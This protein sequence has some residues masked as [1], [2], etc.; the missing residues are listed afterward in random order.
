LVHESKKFV[1][2]LY[3]EGKDKVSAAQKTAKEYTDDMMVQVKK[4]PLASVM[5]AAG[6]GFIISS[7]LRK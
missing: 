6:V 4:N 2:E 1:G 7:I 5:I 3:E